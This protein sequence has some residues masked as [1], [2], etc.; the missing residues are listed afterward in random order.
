MLQGN[1]SGRTIKL[2][3]VP[4][5]SPLWSSYLQPAAYLSRDRKRTLRIVVN[6]TTA[7]STPALLFADLVLADAF[8]FVRPDISDRYRALDTEKREEAASQTGARCVLPYVRQ[9][10]RP[11][12]QRFGARPSG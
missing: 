2:L 1:G 8:R 3:S 9:V 12:G 10:R 5:G 7:C 11:I 4:L 6:A